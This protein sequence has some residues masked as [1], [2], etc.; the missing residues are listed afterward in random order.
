MDSETVEEQKCL[1]SYELNCSGKYFAFKEQLKHAV[2]KI[3]REKYL[4]TTPFE[5]QEELQTFISELYVF[6][7]DQMH[8]ALNQ[9]M[10][11]DIQGAVSTIYTSSEQLRLF[12]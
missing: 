2:V 6:L 5:S 11:D 1:L 8:V 12:A 4:K 7:V 9:T 3:V 10:P